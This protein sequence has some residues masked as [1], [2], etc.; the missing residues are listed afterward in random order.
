MNWY[1]MV[2]AIITGGATG[3]ITNDIAVKM[4]FR[5]F[6]KFGGLILDTRDDFAKEFSNMV[7][8]K[9]LNERTIRNE[10]DK[11]EFRIVAER[12]VRNILTQE[13]YEKT[14]NKTF[15]ELKGFDA[16]YSNIG[17]H[18]VP[19]LKDIMP[20][21]IDLV[22]KNVKTSDIINENQLSYICDE[23]SKIIYDQISDD[24]KIRD[25]FK[26]IATAKEKTLVK[27]IIGDSIVYKLK[28]N[29]KNETSD[30]NELLKKHNL[31]IDSFVSSTYKN[32]CVS[33]AVEQISE[34]IK[35][36][37]LSSFFGTNST[38]STAVTIRSNI[39]SLVRSEEGKRVIMDLSE[40]IIDELSALHFTLFDLFDK[41]MQSKLETTLKSE[42]PKI[43]EK[44]LEWLKTKKPELENLLVNLI[45]ESL[46]KEEGFRAWIK[47]MLW[48]HTDK[49][50]FVGKHQ[51]LSKILTYLK[52][53]TE[54]NLSQI[55]KDITAD[56]IKSLKTTKI[57]QMVNTLRQNKFLT[58]EMTADLI[59]KN[60]ELYK[61]KITDG[62][63]ENILD[64]EVGRIIPDLNNYLEEL[65]NKVVIEELKDKFLYSKKSV[66][67][68]HREI[69]TYSEKF[70]ETR[71]SN[72]LSDSKA[73]KVSSFLK[74]KKNT[75]KE[76]LKSSLEKYINEKTEGKF[77]ASYLDQEKNKKLSNSAIDQVKS[78]LNSNENK[79][80]GTK[81]S[82]FLDKINKFKDIEKKIASFGL[83][84]LS[85]NMKNIIKGNISDIA[86][87]NLKEMPDKVL[88]EKVEN[89]MGK[90]LKVINWFGAGL[91]ALVGFVSYFLIPTEILWYYNI[92]LSIFIFALVGLGTN[93]LALKMLFRSTKIFKLKIWTAVIEKNKAR[94][95]ADLG[96]FVSKE[97]MQEDTLH[98]KYSS[99]KKELFNILNN[100]VKEGNYKLL[101]DYLNSFH[102]DI[103]N[104]IYLMSKEKML[105]D[106]YLSD[107]LTEKLCNTLTSKFVDSTDKLSFSLF[108]NLMD[109]KRDILETVNIK[110]YEYLQKTVPLSKI[111]DENA[112]D[113]FAYEVS[114]ILVSKIKELINTNNT[115]DIVGNFINSYDSIIQKSVYDLTGE[116][117]RKA[118]EDIIK[119]F[120]RNTLESDENKL[121]INNF[122][123]SSLVKEMSG[124]KKIREISFF[125]IDLIEFMSKNSDIV[126]EMIS[127]R[128]REYLTSNSYDIS[129]K[130]YEELK[131]SLAWY[132]PK[133]LLLRASNI[134]V[135]LRI[136]LEN[137]PEKIKA[138]L[139]E[140]T[141]EIK[142][143]FKDILVND[144]G[145]KKLTDLGFEIDKNKIKDSLSKLL[146]SEKFGSSVERLSL[147]LANSL[148]KIPIGECLKITSLKDMKELV[149]IFDEEL[150]SALFELSKSLAKNEDKIKIDTNNLLRIIT[151]DLSETISFNKLTKGISKENI[152]SVISNVDEEIIKLPESEKRIKE[153]IIDTIEY[154]TIKPV[155][156]IID[157]G[158][159]AKLLRVTIK[160]L[161]SDSKVESE[162]KMYIEKIVRKFSLD[163]NI[164]VSL[165]FLD[166]ILVILTESLIDSIEK[167]LFDIIKALNMKKITESEMNKLEN[168]EIEE[169]FY[170]FAGKYFKKLELYGLSGGIFGIHPSTIILGILFQN[171]NKVLPGGNSKK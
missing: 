88:Q 35:N 65:L 30:F 9:I 33:K 129:E 90:E 91:G 98:K 4:I 96:E 148:M 125:G 64:M 36:R 82:K 105:K 134:E 93:W 75:I 10:V 132:N 136:A 72:Y 114:D 22:S 103:S 106:N 16:T 138:F 5:K 97:L 171:I 110:I 139:G 21:F 123:T 100:Y 45:S 63:I 7:E 19:E 109:K 60:I 165:E 151:K 116:K 108:N 47:E 56:I 149:S 147:S 92:P 115:A 117:Q 162:L 77:I 155:G 79:L 26:K 112:I 120:I 158:E 2:L 127:E 40:A 94:F 20:D 18:L 38:K 23:L 113:Q 53:S 71:I 24:K 146:S 137:A 169:I 121:K 11:D 58:E 44:I 42:L 3:Y 54:E 32:L 62:V 142:L 150:N 167:E 17:K 74:K 66:D 13:L 73:D 126:I 161:L 140:K 141:P 1:N 99:N 168:K 41:S 131:G 69:E 29:L 156:Q 37:K 133:K 8:D 128:T 57:S 145:D 80:K 89:F 101:H 144:I 67:L 34:N 68:I 160:T 118:I 59:L 87:K 25:F 85:K 95:A 51:I 14:N 12:I 78:Y 166:E 6:W 170:S 152:A 50:S 43:V 143:L 52:D 70:C 76:A 130:I 81:I 157:T 102:Q 159:F 48:N 39:L 119:K 124:D 31:E 61:D 153:T 164:I 107:L 83:K 104:K 111:F 163:F 49:S 154:V 86:N 46:D 28:N 15:S 122:I 55:S 27:D 135:T 84:E